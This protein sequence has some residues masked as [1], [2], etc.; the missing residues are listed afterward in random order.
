M[1]TLTAKAFNDLTAIITGKPAGRVANKEAAEA[2]FRREAAKAGIEADLILSYGSAYDCAKALGGDVEALSQS[3]EREIAAEA[4]AIERAEQER[5]ERIMKA[6]ASMVSPGLARLRAHPKAEEIRQ[7]TQ[8][9]AAAVTTGVYPFQKPNSRKA[10]LAVIAEKAPEP[11][12]VEKPKKERAAK[13]KAE[14]P[15]AE[16]SRAKIEAEGKITAVVENPKKSGS[17]AHACFSI[18]RAGQSVSDFIAACAEAGIPE[19]EARSNIAWDRRKGFIT[20]EAGA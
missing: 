3:R 6:A 10:A 20:I 17:R 12:K 18:Y 8:A 19:K 14:K 9:E 13:P 4:K 2:R 1:T 15:Q 16:R 11:V 7:K 5:D